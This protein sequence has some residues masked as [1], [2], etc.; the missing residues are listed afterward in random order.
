MAPEWPPF[1]EDLKAKRLNP[2][3]VTG[4]C[5]GKATFHLAIIPNSKFKAGYQIRFIFSIWLKKEDKILLERLKDFF[6]V[7]EIYK[8]GSEGFI[9][10]VNSLKQLEVITRHFDSYLLITQKWSDYQLFRQALEKVKR[11]E[12]LIPKGVIKLV[13]IKASMNLGLNSNLESIFG[14]SIIPVLRPKLLNQDILN[15]H[16]VAGFTSAEGLFYVVNNKSPLSKLGVSVRL[17][18]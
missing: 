3:W 2:F 10:Q 15:Q 9:Y 18:F 16:W 4:F 13:E 7:G 12:H 6:G 17:S 5:D 14:K 8:A 1:R 11:K